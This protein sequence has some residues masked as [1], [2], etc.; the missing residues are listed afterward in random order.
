[1]STHGWH[2]VGYSVA[3]VFLVIGVWMVVD[4]V[5]GLSGHS[6]GRVHFE[7][8]RAKGECRDISRRTRTWPLADVTGAEVQSKRRSLGRGA[9][10]ETHYALALN[11]RD[12]DK[13]VWLSEWTGNEETTAKF[14]DAAS[15]IQSFLAGKEPTLAIKFD[16][17]DSYTWNWRT[18]L[19]GGL[20]LVGV[21][22]LLYFI[23][24]GR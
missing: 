18:L 5:L 6:A 1:M 16:T 3:G 19:D 4:G 17:K 10:F 15:Q 14:R 21:A 2:I 20:I 24:R 7:C 11:L 9:R 12:K 22:V 8:D 23:R 13:E